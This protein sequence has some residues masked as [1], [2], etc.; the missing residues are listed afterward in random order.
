MLKVLAHQPIRIP[1]SAQLVAAREAYLDRHDVRCAAWRG[2]RERDTR[3]PKKRRTRWPS[4]RPAPCVQSFSLVSARAVAA[5]AIANRPGSSYAARSCPA[6]NPVHGSATNPQP[7]C[8]FRRAKMFLSV[9]TTYLSSV[10]RRF[11]SSV[12]PTRLGGCD[13]LK[14]PF[15][16]KIRLELGEHAEHIEKRFSGSVARVDWLFGCFQRDVVRLEIVDDIL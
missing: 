8:D 13:S 1:A 2:S 11:A 12:D 6:K 5:T 10:D 7:T 16:T 15:A 4:P 9:Q 3:L 14:L